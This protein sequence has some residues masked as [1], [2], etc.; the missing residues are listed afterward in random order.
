M[1]SMMLLVLL[2]LSKIL[3]WS[4]PSRLAIL[5]VY[6]LALVRIEVWFWLVVQITTV[7]FGCDGG[8]VILLGG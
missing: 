7:N 4:N 3:V 8:A 1:K 5:D 6:G 2:S